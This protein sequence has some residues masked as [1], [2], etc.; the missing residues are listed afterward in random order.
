MHS[1]IRLTRTPD[2]GQIDIVAQHQPADHMAPYLRQKRERIFSELR[3]GHQIIIRDQK[4]RAAIMRAAEFAD[5]GKIVPQEAIYSGELLCLTA[6]HVASWGR[7]VSA[8]I[9]CFSSPVSMLSDQDILSSIIGQND[10]GRQIE[11]L[12]AEKKDSL[13]EL[14]C[15]IL[16]A[17]K[18]LP[19]ALMARCASSEPAFINRLAESYELAVIDYYEIAELATVREPKLNISSR[20][21]L[22]L[23]AADNSEIV[24]FR[25]DGGTEEHFAVIVGAPEQGGNDPVPLVRLHSQCVTGD[26]LGSLKC[27]C[28]QQLHSSLQMMNEAGYGILLYLEQEGR[29]IGLLNKIRAYALQDKGFDTV[30]ANH[31]L[32][33]NTDERVFAPASAMLKAL[34]CRQIKLLTNNPDKISQLASFD[35]DIISRVA[36]SISPNSH[37]KA[38]LDTKRNRTG[39]L[40]EDE[41]E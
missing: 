6:Q 9:A 32:G 18:L 31:R 17:A 26:V 39:H 28:G 41:P 24:M 12:L 33:F 37:N 36:L 34:D 25:E 30:D 5:F 15:R 38:Y 10:A 20:A 35:I 29:G 22:P 4:G 11:H 2:K 19:A 14:A 23:S 16:R 40:L 1:Y 21:R 13:P 7:T 8:D 3:R 27:D